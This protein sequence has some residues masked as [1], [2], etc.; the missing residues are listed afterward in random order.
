MIGTSLKCELPSPGLPCGSESLLP[1]S[2]LLVT[3]LLGLLPFPKHLPVFPEITS[4][5]NM[6]HESSS[7]KQPLLPKPGPPVSPS[8]GWYLCVF[9]DSSRDQIHPTLLLC[10][11]PPIRPPCPDHCQ[12]SSTD[13]HPSSHHPPQT[14]P[15]YVGGLLKPDGH[16]KVNI[17]QTSHS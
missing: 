13:L 3:P 10:P 14:D 16:R 8:Q 6:W 2:L 12:F 15:C 9:S 7:Q 1:W 11:T 5:W 17:L 4:W